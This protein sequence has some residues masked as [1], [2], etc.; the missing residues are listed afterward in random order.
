MPY[1]SVWR[2]KS[3]RVRYIRVAAIDM[4][5]NE[6]IRNICIGE[7]CKDFD[8]RSSATASIQGRTK[9]NEADSCKIFCIVK[10]EK[11]KATTEIQIY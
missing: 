4:V 3:A 8:I 10:L 6:G 9:S 2:I 11:G 1:I 7:T 5:I